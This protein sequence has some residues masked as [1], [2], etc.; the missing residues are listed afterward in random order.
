MSLYTKNGKPLQVSGTKVYSKSGKIVGKIS[1]NKV[2]G[3]DGKYVGTVVGQRLVYR[4]THSSYVSS[5]FIS[6]NRGG[7]SRSYR[8][9]SSV[10]G[11]EPNIPD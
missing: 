5:S 6:S 8:S 7:S 2:Y 9:A 10:W 11:D 1:R 3:M 4:S